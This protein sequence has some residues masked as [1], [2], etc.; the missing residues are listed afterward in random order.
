MSHTRNVRRIDQA[1]QKKAL[2]SRSAR[3]VPQLEIQ[4]PLT[5]GQANILNEHG[6]RSIEAYRALLFRLRFGHGAERL[7]HTANDWRVGFPLPPTAWFVERDHFRGI[8][9]MDM[10]DVEKVRQHLRVQS[11]PGGLTGAPYPGSLLVYLGKNEHGVGSQ[12]EY[13]FEHTA[14][15]K[16]ERY[17][18]SLPDEWHAYVREKATDEWAEVEIAIDG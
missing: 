6:H 15:D 18:F 16:M 3:Q 10:T 17:T 13:L 7:A 12:V 5:P 11:E 4:G 9:N 8:R 1:R 2:S 14:L